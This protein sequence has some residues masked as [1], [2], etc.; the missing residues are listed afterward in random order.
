[1]ITTCQC[2]CHTHIYDIHIYLYCNVSNLQKLCHVCI[3]CDNCGLW[4]HNKYEIITITSES[5][6]PKFVN[7][8]LTFQIHIFYSFLELLITYFFRGIL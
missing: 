8:T 4:T 3:L 7:E 2:Q 6:R 5:F 1:M